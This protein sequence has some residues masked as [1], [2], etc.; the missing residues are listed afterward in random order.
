MIS[1]AQLRAARGVLDW[2]RSDLAKAASISPETIKNIEHGTFRPQENTADA[3][4]R[5]FGVVG[6]EFIENEGVRKSANTIINYEGKEDFKRY[7]DDVYSA[8]SQQTADRMICI[9]G[10]NDKDFISAL[11]SYADTHLQR[12]QK[13][14]GL[15]FRAL[16][17]EGEDTFAANYIEYRRLPNVTVAIPF[18][19]YAN[20][21]DFIIYG[22][23][24]QYPKV[25][26]I[27]S[28]IVAD[29]YK[30]QFD[31]M[32]KQSNQIK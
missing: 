18:S 28:Q 14:E 21:F 4:V 32:W 13:L 23:G 1:A 8:L 16:M 3:I 11:G 7:A 15:K 31:T 10:N 22:E 2:T 25:V 29:A 20:R 30:I 26:A 9:F 24:S 6:V 5:A 17:A 27:K 19:V 12:M